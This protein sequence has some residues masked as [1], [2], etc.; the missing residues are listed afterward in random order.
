MR[1]ASILFT[2]AVF[3]AC[4]VGYCRARRADSTRLL[5]A[6]APPPGAQ[7]E[8]LRAPIGER[9]LSGQVVDID[10]NPAQGV[11]VFVRSNDVPLWVETDAAGRFRLEGLVDGPHEVALVKWGH[12]PRVARI[13]RPSEDLVL[14]LAPQK[15]PPA[16]LPAITATALV[17]RVAHPLGGSYADEEGYE[18]QFEPRGDITAFGGAV[19]RR[20]STDARG[21]FALEDLAHGDYFVHVVPSWASGGAWP[22]LVAL[23]DAQ[24]EH[25]AEG[26]D[27]AVFGLDA[28]ALE[29]TVLDPAG[30]P[31]DGAYAILSDAA[32]A[33]RVWPPRV[34]NAFGVLRFS[35]LPPG[36]YRLS[37]RA[38]ESPIEE[39]VVDVDAADVAR[40][41]LP[42]L[43]VRKR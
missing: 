8:P 39:L 14:T 19:L 5:P 16:P 38:G 29:G 40:P 6:F 30:Q 32:D 36:R 26:G 37:L 22:D 33:S 24:Y 2:A 13:D 42:R 11:N 35:D 3:V 17:G 1:N 7:L 31:I 12:P 25:S 18:L 21:F 15:A 20:T 23:A 28:G 41:E 10:S 9:V 4:S 27:F 43:A 34:S